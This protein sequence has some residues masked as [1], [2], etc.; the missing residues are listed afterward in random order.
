ME[1]SHG[2]SR[3]SYLKQTNL[4]FFFLLQNQR[5][6]SAQGRVGGSGIGN[7]SVENVGKGCRRVNMVQILC[8]HAC[9]WKNDACGKYYRNGR[10]K[11]N[12]GEGEFK[13]DIFNILQELL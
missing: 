3:C 12:D 11:E 13:Y 4:S 2:N 5:T 1:M 7:R 9:K 6:G 8:T 10:I